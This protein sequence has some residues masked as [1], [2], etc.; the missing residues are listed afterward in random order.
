MNKIININDYFP[1]KYEVVY[2]SFDGCISSVMSVAL[3]SE[4]A[5]KDIDEYPLVKKILS[6]EEIEKG[7]E[8]SNED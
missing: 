7:G 8:K 2:E 4:E 3:N 5:K 1:K 6:V